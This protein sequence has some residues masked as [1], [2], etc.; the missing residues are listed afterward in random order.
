MPR[1]YRFF[2]EGNRVPLGSMKNLP[3]LRGGYAV[4]FED[5]GD[6]LLADLHSQFA[7]FPLD[8][9]VPQSLARAS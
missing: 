8:F 9:A 1:P 4:T 6:G 3:L 2:G 7:Q 5:V